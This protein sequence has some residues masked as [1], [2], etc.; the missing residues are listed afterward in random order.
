MN[1][2]HS[3]VSCSSVPP[4]P[5]QISDQPWLLATTNPFFYTT[6]STHSTEFDDMDPETA[7]AQTPLYS[8]EDLMAIAT[9]MSDLHLDDFIVS[10]LQAMPLSTAAVPG[11]SGSAG[12]ASRGGGSYAPSARPLHTSLGKDFL[13][14][15]AQH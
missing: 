5:E 12:G 3:V 7:L 11:R 10:E 2:L 13:S 6:P 15:F 4:Y 8:S 9:E 14:L 1:Q